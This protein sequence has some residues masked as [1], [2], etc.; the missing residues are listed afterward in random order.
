MAEKVPTFVIHNMFKAQSS[1]IQRAHSPVPHTAT[2]RLM[3]RRILPKR[4]IRITEEE[5]KAHE[6][7]I[8]SK[9]REGRLAFTC[10]DL[11]FVDSR[12]DGRLFITYL[13]KKTDEEPSSPAF[14][15]WPF[16][17]KVAGKVPGTGFDEELPPPPG[18]RT[19]PERS[20]QP[21]TVSEGPTGPVGTDENWDGGHPGAVGDPG[22][23]EAPGVVGP[24]GM[25]EP[26]P[27][28]EDITTEL[29]DPNKLL[30][31]TGVLPVQDDQ[32]ITVD[33]PTKKSKRRK[34]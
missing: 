27:P 28:S 6:E 13:D 29:V 9:V 17:R 1:H 2:E 14:K 26:V 24:E 20:P 31:E 7:E 30:L 21:E 33:M 3:G 4:P 25:P 16:K 8:V 15:M 5:F 18:P 12:P 34:E 10:P 23:V 11:S 32:T 22:V 19:E